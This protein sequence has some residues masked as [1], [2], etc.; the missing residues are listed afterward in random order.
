MA[1][2]TQ[3]FALSALPRTPQIP[4]NVGQ[5][6]V[7]EIYDG[8]RRGLESFELARR[9]P[10]SMA[11]ADAQMQAQTAQ[12]PLATR[13]VLAE[14]EAKEAQL[15]LRTQLLADQVALAEAQAPYRTRILEAQADPRMIEAKILQMQRAGIPMGAREFEMLTANLTSEQ[16]EAARRVH[17]GLQARPSSAA[18]QYKEVLGADGVTR[19]VAVDPRAVGTQVIGSGETYGSGVAP[20][21]GTPVST[22]TAPTTPVVPDAGLGDNP[23]A[24]SPNAEVVSGIGTTSP[25]PVAA[26]SNSNLFASPSIQ[27]Q[28]AAK[29]TGEKS[30]EANVEA[31]TKLPKAFSN[32]KGLEDQT[33]RIED[34]IDAAIANTSPKTAG[35]GAYLQGVPTTGAKTLASQLE[36]IK[37]RIGF[38]ELMSMRQN[39]P[40]GGALGNVSDYEGQQLQSTIARLDQKLDPEVLKVFLNRVKEVRR[41]ALQRARDAY[42]MDARFFGISDAPKTQAAPQS[43]GEYKIIEVR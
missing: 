16:K 4:N 21:P 42:D 9:A 1:V 6:D 43:V 15:P 24:I 12:A 40:T 23:T 37:A 25:A 41:E 17:L 8:V 3:G 36:S 35:F 27:S 13:G 5:I 2:K 32:L 33:K 26:P 39:S 38:Q 19:L 11:L 22:V 20:G 34:D 18:I 7:K 30:A 31:R 28:S 29:A 14:T 10:Q